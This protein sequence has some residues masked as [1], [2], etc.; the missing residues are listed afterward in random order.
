MRKV[1]GRCND[2]PEKALEA[3]GSRAKR[4]EAHGIGLQIR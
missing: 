2:Y 1:V 3:Y 4:L